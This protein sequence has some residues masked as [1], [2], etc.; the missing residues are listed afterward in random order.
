MS[1]FPHL[2]VHSAFSF[3]DGASSVQ[4]LVLRAAEL[5]QLVL[6]LTDMNSITGVPSFVKACGKAGVKPIG[7]CSVFIDSHPLVLLADGPTGW[8]SLCQILTAAGLRDVKR[9][10]LSV[11]WDDLETHHAGLVC[12]SGS[13]S[14]GRLA[15]LIRARRYK[16][17]EEYARRCQTVF[18]VNN[19]FVEITRTLAEGEHEVSC[20]LLEL[21]QHIGA[22]VVAA[23]P[24]HHSLKVG[25]AAH[26][27]LC[28]VRLGLAPED[29]HAEL[30]LNGE[31]YMKSSERMLRLFTDCPQAIANASALAERLAP[32]LNPDVRH[33]PLY[34][35]VPLGESPFSFLAAMTWCGAERRYGELTDTIKS[36]L[37]HEL[38]VI[39][40]LEF[41]DYYL[42]CW[43]ICR[44]SRR[45]G[46]RY[47][48]R[49][50]AV[51]SAVCYALEMSQHDPIKHNVSFERFLSR[52]RKKPPDIDVDFNHTQRDALMQ[53]V[54]DT[55]GDDRVANVSNYVTF[56]ARSLLRDL[57]KVLGFDTGDM[58]RLRELLSYSR[59][60]D[61]A[62][63]IEQT[64]ELREIGIDA[65]Q[66][67]DLFAL[68][69]QIS[70]LPR[71]LGTH[72]SGIVVGDA[73]LAQIAPVTWAAKGVTVLAF[74]KD[75]VEAPGIGLLKIDQLS[76]RALSSIDIAVGTIQERDPDFDYD[77][78][79]REDEATLKMIRSALTVTAFQV[80]SPAQMSLQW[81]ARVERFHDVVVSVALIRPGPIMGGT[82]ET[83]LRRR[84]GE[85]PVSYALPEL[86][87]ILEETYGTIIFQDQVLSVVQILGDLLPDEADEFLKRMTHARDQVAMAALGRS[88]Y[89]RAKGKGMPKK[90]FSKLW[91]GIIGFSRYGFCSGHALAFGDHAQGSSFLLQSHPSDWLAAVLSCAPCG[92]WPV[93]TVTGE[94]VRRGVQVLGP[95]VNRSEADRW[96]LENIGAERPAIRCSLAYVRGLGKAARTVEEERHARGSF[97]SLEELCFR[98]HWLTREQLEWVVLGG[99]LDGLS[100]NRRQ[101]LWSLP[102]LHQN[103]AAQ[104]R[105][106][107]PNAIDGQQALDVPIPVTLPSGMPDFDFG[108]RY[109]QEW[110]VLGFSPKGHPMQFLRDAL[111]GQNVLT[112]SELQS[113]KA[114]QQ[115]KLGGLIVMPHHPPTAKGVLF[116]SLEDETGLAHVAVMPDVYQQV[117]AVIYNGGPV[118]V[119]G[120]AEKRGEGVSLL[121]E[122]VLLIKSDFRDPSSGF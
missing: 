5:G 44:E 56:R 66:Y 86:Q 67:A 71:H 70:G 36:R 95:C 13:S 41:C 26:E 119:T 48:M 100:P 106:V 38:E 117:G 6:A 3:L 29:E 21:A 87:P 43:D 72:S 24:V 62:R 63:E 83:Y 91:R 27:A 23:N 31:Q 25:L 78:R 54:R 90:A 93:S 61:L 32:P 57:G 18:G 55:Y 45:R 59:G 10:G 105:R 20:D 14:R 97:L 74:D 81:R 30:P 35:H 12:L 99:A 73:P 96:V 8:A 51:G 82:V 15:A 118:V 60:T 42:V 11:A 69:A 17:A 7:G 84:H 98:C 76:L 9:Q 1:A 115:V 68:C 46:V 122:N 111:A 104:K 120:R 116:H 77:G 64:P 88:L 49:G 75:D 39:R 92:F 80:E 113:A 110:T 107:D 85:E 58:D 19:F 22:P 112:C 52:G 53:Y 89:E 40:E 2:H 34:P 16:Q 102:T 28:R 121:G 114:G 101:A 94:A 103:R 50:S 37:V 4:D 33:Y 65:A 109:W 108:Q 79:D 47:A